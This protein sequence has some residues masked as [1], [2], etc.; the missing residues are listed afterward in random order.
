MEESL[1]ALDREMLRLV[2]LQFWR[3]PGTPRSW[4]ELPE[5]TK[6]QVRRMYW[7]KME[8]EA[9]SVE[10]AQRGGGSVKRCV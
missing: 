1:E 5:K 6:E 9:H 3:G 4:E 7:E 8:G 10:E 2:H